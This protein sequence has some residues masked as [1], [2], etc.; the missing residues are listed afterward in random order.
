MS[1]TE[2]QIELNRLRQ[3]IIEEL[4]GVD[5]KAANSLHGA[6]L[7]LMT[8]ITSFKE[9]APPAAINAATPHLG[10]LETILKNMLDNPS[11]YIPKPKKEPKKVTLSAQKKEGVKRGKVVEATGGDGRPELVDARNWQHLEV[12]N[13][14]RWRAGRD[15][16]HSVFNGW[17]DKNT[18]QPTDSEDPE[19]VSLSFSD[20]SDGFQ[21]EAYWSEGAYC[22]GSSADRLY[23]VEA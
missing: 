23:V 3:I 18:Q 10:Q 12:G 2:A 15:K 7:K 14:Y 1:K 8:A 17:V 13:E 5:Y 19:E 4:N 16:G 11:S 22:V 6:A 9:K 21:W 20:V